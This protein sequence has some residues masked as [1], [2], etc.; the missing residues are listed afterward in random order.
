MIN[1]HVHHRAYLSGVVL[2]AFDGIHCCLVGQEVEGGKIQGLGKLGR[3]GVRMGQKKGRER[4][5][6]REGFSAFGDSN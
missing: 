4:E 1:H 6:E 5:P 2:F 3:E